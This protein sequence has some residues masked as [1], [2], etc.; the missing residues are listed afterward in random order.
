MFAATGF[1]L[2]MPPVIESA[3][4]T[5]LP[6]L[7]R[8]AL[9]WSHVL[10]YAVLV[11]VFA[12]VLPWTAAARR[13]KREAP[14]EPDVGTRVGRILAMLAAAAFL[15]AVGLGD[16][17]GWQV[18]LIDWTVALGWLV[19]V[20]LRVRELA[21]RGQAARYQQTMAKDDQG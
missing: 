4:F 14:L 6:S 2:V 17:W 20:G 18:H 5:P 16:H 21:G 15:I 3:H 19:L 1:A 10:V 7:E 9:D 13:S 11:F 12:F 8:H